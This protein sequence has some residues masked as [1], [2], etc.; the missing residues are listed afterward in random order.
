[1]KK[2]FTKTNEKEEQ[3]IRKVYEVTIQKVLT[4]TITLNADTDEEAMDCAKDFMMETEIEYLNP[5]EEYLF[6]TKKISDN[7]K[8]YLKQNNISISE[9]EEL[10]D[11]EECYSC[12]YYCP[13]C[14]EC[15]YDE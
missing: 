6:E 1:M 9:S 11:K 15:T 2:I 13:T 7:D 12:E 3:K 8:E 5:K 14:G 10:D 4:K